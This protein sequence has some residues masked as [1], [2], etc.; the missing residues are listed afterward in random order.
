MLVAGA[1]SLVVKARTQFKGE[2]L[3]PW[4]KKELYTT[5]NE[6]DAELE[7]IIRNKADTVYHPVG[8]CRMGSD[9]QAVVDPQLRV[10]GVEGLRIADASIMPRIIGG[11][12][13]AP[14]IM[15]GE[16]C[17]AMMLSDLDK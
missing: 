7:Q 9:D 12:T 17:A 10:R 15:I 14:T 6:S 3:A 16:K 5:G 2:P 11:N 13:N 4:R 1:L 8:T